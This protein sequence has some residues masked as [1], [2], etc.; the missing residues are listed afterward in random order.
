MK[1]VFYFIAYAAKAEVAILSTSL[2]YYPQ[3]VPSQRFRFHW[4]CV[5]LR[6]ARRTETRRWCWLPRLVART[7]R[8]CCWLLAPTRRP[9]HWY[10]ANFSWFQIVCILVFSVNWFGSSRDI[11]IRRWCLSA[12]V[13]CLVCIVHFRFAE[14][15]LCADAGRLGGSRGLRAAAAGCR[16][17]EGGQEPGA[18]VRRVDVYWLL[19]CVRSDEN[20]FLSLLWLIFV[21]CSIRHDVFVNLW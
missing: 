5:F 7:A 8:G 4:F 13:G 21:P 3:F 12:F 15:K 6:A 19:S 14:G 2:L 1:F 18:S 16:R 9:R 17:K 10:D 11:S 20:D